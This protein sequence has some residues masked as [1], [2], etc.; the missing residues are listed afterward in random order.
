MNILIFG[1]QTADQY[2]LLRKAV[3]RKDN[4]LLST[5]IERT[6]VVLRDE[7]KRLP[8]SQRDNFPDFLNISMLVEGYYEKG[9]KIPQLESCLVTFSQLAHY[10]G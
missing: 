9:S 3:L 1:D 2:P 7:I 4:A 10:I 8:R 5:F 6:G